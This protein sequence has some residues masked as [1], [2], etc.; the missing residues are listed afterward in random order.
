MNNP[1][2]YSLGDWSITTAA[3]QVP[4]NDDA[5][6]IEDLEGALALLF[7]ARM[8]YGSGGTNVKVYLQT[9]L[10]QGTTWFDI[11]CIVFTTTNND[12]KV[13]NLSGLT[14]KTTPTQVSDASITDNTCLD[15]VLGDR[16]RVKI[17]STGT[18][19]GSTLVSCRI[20]VR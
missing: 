1:G 6:V 17:V 16:F 5:E 4:D 15:G 13:V 18:Y 3:T 11:A 2:I 8:V 9:S 20:H 7:V 10:D 14:P 12:Q 19:A